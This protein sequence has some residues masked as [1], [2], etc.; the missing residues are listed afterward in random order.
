M[1]L[2]FSLDLNTFK[3]IKFIEIFLSDERFLVVYVCT[4]N[5]SYFFIRI[6]KTKDESLDLFIPV[7]SPFQ[8]HRIGKRTLTLQ[9]T[10]ISHP[11][12]LRPIH[13]K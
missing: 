12:L 11:R 6:L 9:C 13:S 1:K 7:R 10:L 8:L 3:N 4:T 2:E 5:S